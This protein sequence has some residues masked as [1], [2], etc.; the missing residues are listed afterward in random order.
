M[1]VSYAEQRGMFSGAQAPLKQH[2]ARNDSLTISMS[3]TGTID[4]IWKGLQVGSTITGNSLAETCEWAIYMRTCPGVV[5]THSC[6]PTGQKDAH[7]LRCFLDQFSPCALCLS[8]NSSTTFILPSAQSLLLLWSLFFGLLFRS[9]LSYGFSSLL[10][11]PVVLSSHS[12]LP[13]ILI[14][15]T[16]LPRFSHC[17]P[18]PPT[19]L[20]GEQ[21]WISGRVRMTENCTSHQKIAPVCGSHGCS[22]FYS[23]GLQIHTCI[24]CFAEL[25]VAKGALVSPAGNSHQAGDLMAREFPPPKCTLA[26]KCQLD[27]INIWKITLLSAADSVLQ[28]LFKDFPRGAG[29]CLAGEGRSWPHCQ[30]VLIQKKKQQ[31]AI[32][33]QSRFKHSAGS[34]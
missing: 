29:G 8:P 30:T 11:S 14:C 7:L 3:N 17:S 13:H 18:I 10:T 34:L 31:E 19:F 22:Q 5:Q 25:Q 21:S 6:S 24:M 26:A 33:L 16:T 27:A 28:T 2:L 1:Q 9:S 15:P 23:I 4:V 32:Y 12:L 20:S